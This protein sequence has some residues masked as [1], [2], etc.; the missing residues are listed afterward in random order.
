[1]QGF[2]ISTR[3]EPPKCLLQSR[4]T[5]IS[6]P[7]DGLAKL[8]RGAYRTRYTGSAP[9]TRPHR[10]CKRPPRRCPCACPPYLRYLYIHQSL[11]Q[12]L[13]HGV[14]VLLALTCLSLRTSSCA[15]CCFSAQ[16]HSSSRER[17]DLL[18]APGV[19]VIGRLKVLRFALSNEPF[20]ETARGTR[21]QLCRGFNGCETCTA[22]APQRDC[23]RQ[24]LLT[25]SGAPRHDSATALHQRCICGC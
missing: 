2:A 6:L 19:V 11:G 8:Q 7:T 15:S 23:M 9:E 16:T 3:P 10:R 12:A 18:I 17:L 21:S 24:L 5:T 4:R 14:V 25:F 22:T 1:M 20:S 13:G